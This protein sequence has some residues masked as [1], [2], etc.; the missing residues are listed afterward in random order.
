MG[1]AVV[2]AAVTGAAGALLGL[3]PEA[4]EQSNETVARS[5]K[6]RRI[7]K[8]SEGRVEIEQHGP[9]LT[10]ARWGD[11]PVPIPELQGFVVGPVIVGHGGISNPDILN[12]TTDPSDGDHRTPGDD[13]VDEPS[14]GVILRKFLA[15]GQNVGMRVPR[16]AVETERI[17]AVVGT[18]D[19]QS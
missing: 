3:Q 2:G 6:K 12:S 4:D 19:D 11:C 10:V 9:R 15:R 7:A 18:F 14:N 17:I 13:D 16:I 1:S 5:V 8:T